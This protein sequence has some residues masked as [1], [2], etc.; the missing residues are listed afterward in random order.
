[1]ENIMKTIILFAVLNGFASC[2]NKKVETK[3][4]NNDKALSHIVDSLSSKKTISKD[5]VDA[6]LT[7]DKKNEDKNAQ[8]TTGGRYEQIVDEKID[9]AYRNKTPTILNDLLKSINTDNK[10]PKN[11]KNYWKAYIYYKQSILYKTVNDND[12]A[13]K[14]IDEAL[15]ILQENL[16]TSE[17]YALYAACK[18]FSIQFAN[19][20]KLASIS[21]EAQEYADK[22]LEINP[23][24]V[25]AY[26]VLASH[27]FYTPKMFGGMTKV[28][29]YCI[30]GI[31]LPMTSSEDY[32]APYWGKVDIYRL[33]I[34][35]YETEGREKDATKIKD[36]A[37][38]EFPSFF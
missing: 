6:H 12:K 14:A 33:L 37:K 3:T 36:L 18:S 29:Q 28:E 38:K 19:M 8:Q 30:K 24:N 11:F 21:A 34:K 32:Y 16:K 7:I 5:T 20:T 17:D 9:V 10:I 27:N 26:Y 31:A 15:N 25:R 35:F 4:I 22:S 13:S 23:K 2:Q 1:M